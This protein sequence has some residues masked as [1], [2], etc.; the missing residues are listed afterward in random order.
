MLYHNSISLLHMKDERV[1]VGSWPIPDKP[2]FAELIK[3]PLPPVWDPVPWEL[4]F[5]L[6]EKDTLVRVAQLELKYSMQVMAAKMEILKEIE[7]VM[8]K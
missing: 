2:A 4:L 1:S 7:R 3:W 5:K 6:F 8:V